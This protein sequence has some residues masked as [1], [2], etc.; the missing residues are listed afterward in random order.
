MV[1]VTITI[2]I[3]IISMIVTTEPVVL[4]FGTARFILFRPFGQWIGVS[5]GRSGRVV[6]HLGT[7][8]NHGVVFVVVVVGTGGP[9]MMTLSRENLGGNHKGGG[10][11]DQ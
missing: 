8:T 1:V 7:T 2:I 4:D 5:S 9:W 11:N 6:H 3:S 10:Y